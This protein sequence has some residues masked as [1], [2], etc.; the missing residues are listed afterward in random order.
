MPGLRLLNG[1]RRTIIHGLFLFHKHSSRREWFA[2]STTTKVRRWMGVSKKKCALK[3]HT[4]CIFNAQKNLVMS[5]EF[6]IG[7]RD[8]FISITTH[9]YINRSDLFFVMIKQATEDDNKHF[10]CQGRSEKM[11]IHICHQ[12]IELTFS[13]QVLV[14]RVHYLTV[15]IHLGPNHTM[16]D[17][18]FDQ[19]LELLLLLLIIY[20]MILE[21]YIEIFEIRFPRELFVLG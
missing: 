15:F 18:I 10:H 19:R 14:A 20:Q 12:T 11:Y 7:N 3:I 17:H 1:C 4:V 2:L 8:F 6:C 21:R 13:D 9:R 16:T 5:K